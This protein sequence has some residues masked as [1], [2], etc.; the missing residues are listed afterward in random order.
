MMLKTLNIKVMKYHRKND[1]LKWDVLYD[2]VAVGF[3]Q[4]KK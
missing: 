2:K 1:F 4:N 3:N